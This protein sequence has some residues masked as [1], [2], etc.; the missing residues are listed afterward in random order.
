MK[1]KI[2]CG[3]L[4]AAMMAGTLV[5]CGNSGSSSGNSGST[6][7]DSTSSSAEGGSEGGDSSVDRSESYEVNFV[8]LVAQEGTEYQAIRD[9]A[10]ELSTA[11]V[12]CTVNLIPTT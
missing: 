9:K 5:S 8:Y 4:C 12:N 1:K 6:G 7:G 2:L 3:L 10:N 11:A